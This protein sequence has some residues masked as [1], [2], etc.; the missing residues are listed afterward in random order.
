[1]EQIYTIPVNEAFD[2]AMNG[3]GAGCPVCALYK[4]LEDTELDTILGA[5]MMEPDIRIK[6][7]AM[8][9]C[10]PHFS[11]MAEK[12]N[13]LSLALML[14][15]HLASVREL[16]TDPPLSTPGDK[17]VKGLK[18][19]E[20]SCYLCNKIDTSLS[21]MIETVVFLWEKDPAFGPKLEAQ[22]RFC[23]PH[24]RRLA[25]CGRAKLPKK[26]YAA[27]YRSLKS[28]GLRYLEKLEGDVSWFCK[29]FDYRY[30][31]E[32]WYDAK[33]S[34]ERAVALLTATD[35][36]AKEGKGNS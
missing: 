23:L 19:L 6:T 27:F 34:I 28:V 9:F 30:D 13:R 36:K 33:D 1:M 16:F 15:S 7:N 26:Q 17:T 32:P 5:S 22:P 11:R 25:E 24:Y 3:E 18:E 12:R 10:H 35:T 29:K 20:N 2:S 8:G 4:K 21:R 14:E 31:A